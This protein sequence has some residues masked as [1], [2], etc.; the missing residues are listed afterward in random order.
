MS[1]VHHPV[2]RPLIPFP[3]RAVQ[4]L[5]LTALL[6]TLALVT[7]APAQAQPA[8]GDPSELAEELQAALELD[9]D[10]TE[11]TRQALLGFAKN[12]EGLHAQQEAAEEPDG[13]AML[14]GIGQARD[15]FFKDM[16]GILSKEQNAQ[17]Q[18]MVD[19]VMNEI[20]STVAEIKL[21][22][23]QQPLALSDEQLTQ[24]A[25]VMG[26]SIR[27]IFQLVMDAAGKRMGVPQKLKMARSMKKI[28]ADTDAQLATILTPQQ[29]QQMQAM[30]E[31]Q[32]AD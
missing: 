12:L 27:S 9:D 24:M 13:Q 1:T 10:Q 32:K 4:W 19:E 18:G 25:P 11:A 8:M 6:L 17:F 22:D 14:A 29:Q 16:A 28:K 15:A 26:T 7:S 31:Q 2:A 3:T 20:F 30:R 5:L 21:I 23:L